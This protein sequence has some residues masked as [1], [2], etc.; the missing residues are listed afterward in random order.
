MLS[1]RIH[2]PLPLRLI[3]VGAVIT[4][5]ALAHTPASASAAS[6]AISPVV[7]THGD[8][9]V[10][11]SG[12]V[13]GRVI[14]ISLNGTFLC[15]TKANPDGTFSASCSL[16]KDLSTGTVNATVTQ[17]GVVLGTQPV[18][19]QE[20][21]DEPMQPTEVLQQLAQGAAKSA[22]N[23][24]QDLIKAPPADEDTVHDVGKMVKDTLVFLG[25][26]GLEALQHSLKD[27]WHDLKKRSL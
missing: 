3:L 14:D 27:L 19:V 9:F 23:A 5:L 8:I 20:E 1:R 12:A 18:T 2:V 22:T 25:E 13:P 10:A 21:L 15:E 6:V 7:T 24:L 17:T 11:G 4:P 16:P 26:T